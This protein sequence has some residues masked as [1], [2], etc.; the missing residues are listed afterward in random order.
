[1]RWPDGL[2]GF[3]LRATQALAA[4]RPGP[5]ALLATPTVEASSLMIFIGCPWLHGV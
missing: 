3:R 2:T 4:L 5:F 1:M